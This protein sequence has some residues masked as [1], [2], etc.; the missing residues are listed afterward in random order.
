MS[1]GEP[2]EPETLTADDRTPPRREPGS[3]PRSEP[4]SS[5]MSEPK[6][7]R[8][9]A[10]RRRLIRAAREELV[11]REGVLEIDSVAARASVSVG[12]I[13]R[14]FESRAGLVSAVVDDFYTRY[15]AE[16]LEVNPAPGRASRSENASARS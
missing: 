4:N 3:L 7:A 12:A 1:Q 11:E 15:R 14:H 8:G 2:K 10:T 16:A 6:T 9:A 5:P 13:Y